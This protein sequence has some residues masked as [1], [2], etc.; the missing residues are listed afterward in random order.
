ML[1]AVDGQILRFF[2][3]SQHYRKPLAFSD[4]TVKDAENNLKKIKNAYDKLAF[5][6]EKNPVAA[7]ILIRKSMAFVRISSKRWTMISIFQMATAYELT[8]C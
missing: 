5:E 2:L 3:V 6:I 7:Q 8:T 4:D 1:Q